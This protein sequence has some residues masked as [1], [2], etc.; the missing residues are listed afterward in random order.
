[1]KADNYWRAALP[2]YLRLS[3]SFGVMVSIAPLVITVFSSVW[4]RIRTG[5]WPIAGIAFSLILGGF[6]FFLAFVTAVGEDMRRNWKA[7][8]RTTTWNC[9]LIWPELYIPWCSRLFRRGVSCVPSRCMADRA[10]LGVLGRFTNN[11]AK[12][13]LTSSSFELSYHPVSLHHASKSET[14]AQACAMAW[15]RQ[16][17]FPRSQH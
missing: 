6:F 10:L 2:T 8:D 1:M 3:L 11:S 4:V 16:L 7:H 17:S 13:L 14:K 15:F 12:V 5:H 9:Q